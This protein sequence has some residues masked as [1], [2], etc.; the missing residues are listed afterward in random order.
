MS[1]LMSAATIQQIQ[2]QVYAPD[3]PEVKVINPR[4]NLLTPNKVITTQSLNGLLFDKPGLQ[5]IY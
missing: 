3:T 4:M 2:F 5:T 1:F